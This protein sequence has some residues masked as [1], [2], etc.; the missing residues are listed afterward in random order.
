MRPIAKRVR[1][2]YEFAYQYRHQ[3]QLLGRKLGNI[4]EI[5]YMVEK[6]NR[7]LREWEGRDVSTDGFTERFWRGQLKNIRNKQDVI[8]PPMDMRLAKIV[9][10]EVCDILNSEG[11]AC[12]LNGGLLL[13][14]VREGGFIPHDRDIDLGVF[15]ESLKPKMA[16]LQKKFTDRGFTVQMI[17]S[18]YKYPR[19]FKLIKL[20]IPVDVADFDIQDDTRFCIHTLAKYMLKVPAKLL[21]NMDK[22]M[23]EGR[24]FNIPTPPEEYLDIFYSEW[25]IPST[26]RKHNKRFKV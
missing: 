15:H 3:Y 12:F 7:N 16:A 5:Y 10:Y 25:K 13:G 8:K 9:M 18:Y 17:D 19:K 2:L 20:G 1:D 14:S 23:F 21:D 26:E 24:E 11:I 22:V 4:E 6:M